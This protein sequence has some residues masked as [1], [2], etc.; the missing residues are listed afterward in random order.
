MPKLWILLFCFNLGFAIF[1]AVPI[2]NLLQDKVGFQITL[3]KSVERFDFTFMADFFNQYGDLVSG[4]VN[5]GILVIFLYL[6]FFV[7]LTGGILHTIIHQSGSFRGREFWGGAGQY[8]WKILRLL[9]Y[10]GLIHAIVFF[11]FAYVF[12]YQGID[13]LKMESD[14]WII[15]R[16]QWMVP[17]LLFVHVL[18]AMV[19]D[20]VKVAVVQYS[21]GF[22]QTTI[23]ERAIWIWRHFLHSL[24][25]Y[26][27]NILVIILLFVLYRS[28]KGLFPEISSFGI[29]VGFFL[30]QVY[31][32][33]R[34]GL[35]L[36]NFASIFALVEKSNS[37]PAS[38]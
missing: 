7:F 36:V 19:H 33:L 11:L 9:I 14:A 27:L 21:P 15:K 12:A 1:I 17:F 30:A 3:D 8:F 6:L 26:L 10:F 28:I 25:L 23:K 16:S 29:I 31:I 4:I 37:S 20:F 35:K 22:M 24:G 2:R 5:H 34:V 32:F 18:I 13:P 38:T